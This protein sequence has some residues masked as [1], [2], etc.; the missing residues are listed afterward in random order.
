M[1]TTFSD[2][3]QEVLHNWQQFSSNQSPHDLLSKLADWNTPIFSGDIIH[4]WQQ[5]PGDFKNSWHEIGANGT[6]SIAQARVMQMDLFNYY[7]HL[8]LT[9][10]QEL[11][12]EMKGEQQ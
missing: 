6:E 5:M 11:C 10:Y 12:E 8:F 4:E 9:A 1:T 3:K 2:I 7:N